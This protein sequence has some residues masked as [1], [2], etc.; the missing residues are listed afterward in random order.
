MDLVRIAARIA[1]FDLVNG[2][3]SLPKNKK[4]LTYAEWCKASGRDPKDRSYVLAW[5]QNEDPKA[6]VG[7]DAKEV[8]PL[9]MQELKNTARAAVM[10]A[11]AKGTPLLHETA[12][13]AQD[14]LAD[15]QEAAGNASAARIARKVAE[16]QREKAA[17]GGEKTDPMG[18][19]PGWNS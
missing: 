19:G 2:P 17:Q 7:S 15:A 18:V 5:K 11:N 3:S 13:L 14:A 6:F 16:L 9:D 10:E 12:A 8:K 1:S 4:G